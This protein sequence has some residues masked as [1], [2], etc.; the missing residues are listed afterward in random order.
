MYAERRSIHESQLLQINV[1]IVVDPFD[2]MSRVL[3][4]MRLLGAPEII[5]RVRS[6]DFLVTLPEMFDPEVER[7]S[8]CRLPLTRR[9]CRGG[10]GIRRRGWNDHG[11]QRKLFLGYTEWR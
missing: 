5:F 8:F 6:R 11:W 9:S 2:V 1:V 7:W 10:W 4:S 3:G